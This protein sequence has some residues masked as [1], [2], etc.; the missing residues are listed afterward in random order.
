MLEVMSLG[1]AGREEDTTSGENDQWGP[2]ALGGGIGIDARKYVE[3]LL[4]LNR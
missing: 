1:M 3:G 2:G 4:S